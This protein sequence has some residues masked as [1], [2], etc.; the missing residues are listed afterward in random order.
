[1]KSDARINA[2]LET[3][4]FALGGT[5][6]VAGLDKFT[7]LLVDWD[8]YLS[9]IARRNL[10]ISPRNFMRLVGVIEM[11]VGAMI[12][13]RQT[14]VGGYVASAW[15]LGISANLVSSGKYLDIAARDVNLAVAAYALAKLTEAR[16]AAEQ[17]APFE[18]E[19]AA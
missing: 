14:R 5:A 10:P 3:L 8:K 17:A 19:R 6:I 16:Q 4:R 13:R 2:A 9:P 15:L 12:L 11:A 7:N 1:M 18:I